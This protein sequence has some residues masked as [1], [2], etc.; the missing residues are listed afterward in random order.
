MGILLK[1]IISRDLDGL[2]VDQVRFNGKWYH[3]SSVLLQQKSDQMGHNLVEQQVNN[4]NKAKQNDKHMWDFVIH[5][6]KDSGS[7]DVLM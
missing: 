5:R 6:A 3:I 7:G 4:N 1:I 2:H